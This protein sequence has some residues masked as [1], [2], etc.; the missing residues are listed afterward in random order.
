MAEEPNEASYEADEAM[1]DPDETDISHDDLE[2]DDK[3][4]SAG[5]EEEDNQRENKMK[6]TCIDTL[7]SY[8][9]FFTKYSY[10]Y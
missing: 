4:D 5:V 8:D 3:W 7:E 10:I 9:D 1:H 6:H 2:Q